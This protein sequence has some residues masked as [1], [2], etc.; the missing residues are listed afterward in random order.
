VNR[1]HLQDGNWHFD[2][3]LFTVA[4]IYLAVVIGWL[5]SKDKLRLPFISEQPSPRPV[6]QAKPTSAADPKFIAYVGSSL[7]AIARRS[8]AAQE[9]PPAPPTVA[10]PPAVSSDRVPPPNTRTIIEKVYVPVYPQN[11]APIAT[12]PPTATQRGT[13]PPPPPS[14]VATQPPVSVNSNATSEAN[15]IDLTLVGLLESGDR[16]SALFKIDNATRRIELGEAIGSSGW[17]LVSVQNQQAIVYANG[18][19][20]SLEVGQGF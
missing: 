7:E 4:S 15:K 13:Q 17:T 6:E 11:Q 3:I 10:I 12:A 19:T 8:K 2:K 14:S 18:K 16:S 9:T 20:R 5:L 1:H